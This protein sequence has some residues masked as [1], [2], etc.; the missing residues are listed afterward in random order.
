MLQPLRWPPQPP[1]VGARFS[2]APRGQNRPWPA[3]EGLS[4][5][6]CPPRWAQGGFLAPTGSLATRRC[7]KRHRTA[8]HGPSRALCPHGHSGAG[9]KAAPV[10]GA[11]VDTGTCGSEHGARGAPCPRVGAVCR[12]HARLY[13]HGATRTILLRCSES[14][15]APRSD[16]RAPG[17][18]APSHAGRRA[19]RHG[20]S[21]GVLLGRTCSGRPLPSA[22]CGVGAP[23]AGTAEPGARATERHWSQVLQIRAIKG[24]FP[25]VKRGARHL[26]RASCS[27]GAA[28]AAGAALRSRSLLRAGAHRG[29]GG[30]R[31]SYLGGQEAGCSER[32]GV[33]PY[34]G[35]LRAVSAAVNKRFCGETAPGLKH[36][37]AQ[38]HPWQRGPA[39]HRLG[40]GLSTPGGSSP[41]SPGRGVGCPT[42][43]CNGWEGK[44][45][46]QTNKK[47][48]KNG[49]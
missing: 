6:R 30:R 48:G 28:G 18:C 27:R 7:E 21:R 24:K 40:P 36:P 31:R 16:G 46:T 29:T 37:S 8:R 10:L 2:I 34:F 15:G 45:K 49:E 38:Q 12:T 14:R 19:P 32:L 43:L 11:G 33:Q 47:Q 41:A 26:P 23:V 1:A 3:A 9:T 4:P 25:R 5:L 42:S 17:G 13:G 20:D 22:G 39:L 35:R 44:K